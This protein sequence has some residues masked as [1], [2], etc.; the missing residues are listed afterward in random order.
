MRKQ[1]PVPARGDV[2]R[3]SI[4]AAAM[5]VFGRDGFHAASTRAIAN[6][7]NTNQALIG[8]HFGNKQRLYLT[9][10]EHIASRIETLL[11][12]AIDHI[13]SQLARPTGDTADAA[14]LL[15]LV[16]GFTAMLLRDETAVW[17]RLIL[18]EQQAP[19]AAFDILYRRVIGRIARLLSQLI[20]RLRG[21]SEAVEDDRLTAM[22]LIGQVLV[23]RVARAAALRHLGWSEVGDTQVAAITQRLRANVIAIVGLDAAAAGANP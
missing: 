21:R 7:A 9:V 6:A 2:T 22:T 3:E 13:E 16:S 4:L 11:G 12:P 23:F 10:F 20:A 14:L 17:A 18:R 15:E 19:S 1:H 5:E 8:Y